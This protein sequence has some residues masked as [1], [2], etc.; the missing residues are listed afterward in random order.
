MMGSGTNH[1]SGSVLPYGPPVHLLTREGRYKPAPVACSS[2]LARTV[3]RRGFPEVLSR[4]PMP[5]RAVPELLFGLPMPS[6][7]VPELLFGLRKPS[8]AV[9]EL[10]SGLRGPSRAVPELLV[11]LQWPSRAVG[12]GA[13]TAR[14]HHARSGGSR[15][16]ESLA[17]GRAGQPEPEDLPVLAFARG[18]RRT[19]TSGPACARAHHRR[20]PAPSPPRTRARARHS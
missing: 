7:A 14:L 16:L 3:A 5:S 19:K 1:L 9:P 15:Q 12:E 11:E 10:L 20:W 17:V 13:R 4:L 18:N 8:R 6:R 2:P